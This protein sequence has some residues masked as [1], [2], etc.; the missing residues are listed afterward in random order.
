MVLNHILRKSI[1]Q[2]KPRGQRIYTRLSGGNLIYPNSYL[3]G[4]HSRAESAIYMAA[5]LMELHCHSKI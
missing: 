2:Y 4:S 1:V 5:G 3:H